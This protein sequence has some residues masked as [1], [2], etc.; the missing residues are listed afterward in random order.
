[1]RAVDHL[2]VDV[3]FNRVTRL[4]PDPQ[5]GHE[6]HNVVA[7][8][9]LCE[10]SELAARCLGCVVDGVCVICEMVHLGCYV[11]LNL[12]FFTISPAV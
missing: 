3:E 1:M 6:Y 11:Y 7:G 12:C 9:G 4:A 5:A 10:C 8:E 2:G